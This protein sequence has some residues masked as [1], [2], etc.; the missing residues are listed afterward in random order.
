M[1]ILFPKRDAV[2]TPMKLKRLPEDFRV[3]E[4]P[5]VQPGASGRFVFYRLDKTGLGTFEAIEAIR[6]RW[7]LAADSI[8]HGGLKDRHAQ[9]IQYLTILDGPERPLHQEHLQLEPLGRLPHP[10]GPGSFS[11]N[12][13]EIVL[14]DL[15]ESALERAERAIDRCKIDGLPNYFDDQRF[16]SLGDSGEFIA[17]AWLAGNPERALFLAIAEATPLDR[18]E[19]RDIKKILREHWN[20]WPTLKAKLPRSSERS[21]ITYLVDHPL[22]FAGAFA[23]SRR[24]LRSIQFS[25]YQSQLWNL[26][27]ARI[28]ERETDERDRVMIEFK[29]GRLPF[30]LN[31]NADTRERFETLRIPLPSARSKIPEDP[32]LREPIDA[33]LKS[34]NLEWND[35]RIKKLKDLF[36]SKGERPALFFPRSI[37]REGLDDELYTGRRKLKLSFELSKGSYATII[38]KRATV[39]A[40]DEE[41]SRNSP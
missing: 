21:L 4:L 19:T 32:F 11:G 27:L 22:D 35:L 24:D 38:V 31:F 13:F 7:N 40:K 15:S 1:P 39:A 41:H 9:T 5:A 23:R 3:E 25:A 12:R 29:S 34:E 16:G 33:V 10:Y 17:R 18:P 37:T 14:R 20:D 2:E 26:V 28:L 36:L 30:P 8:R 6:R